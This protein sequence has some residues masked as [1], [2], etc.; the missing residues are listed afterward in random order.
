MCIRD[1]LKTINHFGYDEKNT[2]RTINVLVKTG[3]GDAN[4]GQATGIHWHMNIANKISYISDEK[5]QNITYVKAVGRD[6]EVTEYLS[7]I[8]I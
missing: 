8:H 1:R 4:N 7:L 5:R 2:Q 6:G 3:G